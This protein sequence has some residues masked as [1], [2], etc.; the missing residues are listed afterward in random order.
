MPQ[1]APDFETVARRAFQY[2]DTVSESASS[3][4]PF[5]TRDIEP[6]LAEHARALFDDGHY[7]QA[8]F[9]VMKFIEHEV[10]RH[11]GLSETGVK[12]MMQAFGGDPARI[13][14]TPCQ[15]QSEKDEQEGYRFLFAGA[16]S[17]I[18]NPR[19]HDIA[20]RESPEDCLDFLAFGSML[21]R[22]LLAAGYR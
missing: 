5:E 12:L 22:R 20:V 17:A 18:R 13:A 21:T 14:L 8:T 1:R 11:S 9:E 19:G 6:R 2:S 7:A 16:M 4:H 10:R 3:L 15:T